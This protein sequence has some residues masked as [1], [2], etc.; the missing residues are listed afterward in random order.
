MRFD[1]CDQKTMTL[2]SALMAGAPEWL[3]PG[4]PASVVLMQVV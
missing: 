4:T 1:A 2:A 3:F